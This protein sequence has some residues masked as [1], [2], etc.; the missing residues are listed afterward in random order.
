[1]ETQREDEWVAQCTRRLRM[2]WPTLDLQS[3]EEVARELW[4]DERLRSQ[5]PEQAATE[6]LRRGMPGV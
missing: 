2:Q 1:M 3:L 5:R 6:W 4:V